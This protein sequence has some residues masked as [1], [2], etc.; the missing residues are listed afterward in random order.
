MFVSR[1]I[2]R[3]IR[4]TDP[5]TLKVSDETIQVDEKCVMCDKEIPGGSTVVRKF[6]NHRVICVFCLGEIAEIQ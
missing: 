3:E 4:T 2:S 6:E 5:T 1:A